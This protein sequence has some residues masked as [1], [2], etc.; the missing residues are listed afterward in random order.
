[1][2]VNPYQAY[3]QQ[4]IMTMTQG[5]MLNKLFEEVIKQLK[6]AEIYIEEKN[7]SKSN[8]S[9]QKAQKILHHLSSTLNFQYDIANNLKA[10]YDFFIG[11][12]VSANI[13]KSSESLREIIPML[14]DLQEAFLQADRIV[15]KQ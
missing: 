9:L 7:Y 1:M 5:E 12:V 6:L 2:A 4:S 15:R 13:R 14:E 11:R 10:L 8:Y 3:K